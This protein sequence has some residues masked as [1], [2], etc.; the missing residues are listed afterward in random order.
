MHLAGRP[1][2]PFSINV[3]ISEPNIVFDRS[4][5]QKNILQYDCKIRTQVVKVP[6]ADIHAIEQNAALL[7]VVKPHQQIGDGRFAGACVAD[8]RDALAEVNGKRYVLQHPIFVLVREPDILK[9]DAARG[10][11]GLFGFD[12]RRY[13]ELAVKQ[14]KDAVRRD[15]R[16]LQDVKFV[17]KGRGWAETTGANIG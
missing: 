4:A 8:K 7:N 11:A 14:N 3:R 17:R 2:Y 1:F 5:K 10:L 6:I 16:G 12:R 15:D 9:F 13:L